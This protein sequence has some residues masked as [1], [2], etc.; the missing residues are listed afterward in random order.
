MWTT[1]HDLDCSSF[2]DRKRRRRRKSVLLRGKAN[3]EI[4]RLCCQRRNEKKEKIPI[5]EAARG[6]RKRPKLL[7]HNPKWKTKQQ[8][9]RHMETEIWKQFRNA[10]WESNTFFLL[11]A[12]CPQRVIKKLN[13]LERHRWWNNTFMKFKGT[14]GRNK[15]DGEKWKSRETCEKFALA[16][17]DGKMF[18]FCL[19]LQ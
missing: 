19:H 12:P 1:W 5:L 6:R 15:L 8:A 17:K 13:Y 7:G 9:C 14:K 3:I 2:D 16:S 10:L 11:R 18:P 4:F